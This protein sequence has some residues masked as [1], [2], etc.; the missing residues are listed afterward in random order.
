MPIN[1][2]EYLDKAAVEYSTKTAYSDG[3]DDMS[4]AEV[5]EKS[6]AIG[7]YLA[8]AGINKKPVAVFMRRHPS[9]IAAYFGVI[10]AGCFY[11]P[12]DEEMPAFRIELILKNIKPEIIIC[13]DYTQ[14]LAGK[15]AFSSKLLRYEDMIG[16]EYQPELLAEIR[17]K[18]ID[19]DLV[20][21]VFTSGSTG[22]PKGVAA[23]HRNIIDYIEQLT[24]ILQVNEK[25][26]FG[27]QTP[28]YLD[29]CLKEL[30]PVLKTGAKTYLI[31][32]QLFS[33]PLKLVEYI[34]EHKINTI[35]WVVTALT[36]ISGL[37]VLEKSV[38]SSLH[39]IAFASEVFP[40][41][42]F[43]LWRQVLPNARF[44]NFYGPTEATGVCCF[45]EVDR[46][47]ADD[48]VIP[49]G[50]PFANRE[51]FLIKEDG[52]KAL[53]EEIGEIYIRGS[54]LTHGYY[55]DFARS[56]EVFVQNPL[57]DKY[58][59]LVYKTGDLGRFNDKGQLVFV[60]R[61]DFQI[62]H[63]G[64]RIE[65]GE[66]ESA[67]AS[68][69]YSELVGCVYDKVKKRIILFYTGEQN[70]ARLRSMLIEKL[71]RYMLPAKIVHLLK[72]PLTGN[73]KID[74]NELLNIYI[75]GGK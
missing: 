22:V 67:A 31:P 52:S 72:M 24:E 60:S 58:H 11:I 61:K 38:P 30:I 7:S 45:Y 59:E 28:L 26:I 2:L 16:T 17:T 40:I 44:I 12:L 49:I 39:T 55:N 36:M 68:S 29:A 13:D 27:N 62:K 48:E 46:D 75:S 65:L 23:C 15:F 73:Q 57:N 74:R 64:H 63:M 18:A 8:R 50:K 42:Q 66:I 51:I 1:I 33:F 71:P 32:K 10:S 19:T 20:Y 37:N 21:I 56:S 54:S 6:H 9:T 5:Q 69:E 53:D 35:C 43:R 47:F 3:T 34:N 41:R 25:T 14:T 4:F 70:D